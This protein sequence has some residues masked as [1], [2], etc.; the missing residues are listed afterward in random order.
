[1]KKTQKNF[2]RREA[3]LSGAAALA[4]LTA[5]VTAP[6]VSGKTIDA[7][8]VNIDDEASI[9]RAVLDYVEGVYEVDPAKIERSVHPELAKRGFYVKRGETAYSGAPMTFTQLV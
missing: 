4:G 5:A 2:T 6:L 3:I 1:M 8:P 7:A 9:R